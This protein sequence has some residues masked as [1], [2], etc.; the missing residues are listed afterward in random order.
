MADFFY[1]DIVPKP[2]DIIRNS[3]SLQYYSINE[4]NISDILWG[5][6]GGF[7][8]SSQNNNVRIVWK[9]DDPIKSIS[10]SGRYKNGAAFFK[11]LEVK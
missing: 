3:D 7:I 11:T 1:I 10:V 6:E 8:I 5:I 9:S 2:I 4:M